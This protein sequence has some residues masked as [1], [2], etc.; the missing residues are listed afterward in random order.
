[1]LIFIVLIVATLYMLILA[2]GA[3]RSRKSVPAMIFLI[4]AVLIASIG[5]YFL[6]GTFVS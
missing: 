5:V 6:L 2:F 3:F 4:S 1:M